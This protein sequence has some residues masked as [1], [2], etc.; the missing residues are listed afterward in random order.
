[1]MLR[2]SLFPKTLLSLNLHT[3]NSESSLKEFGKTQPYSGLKEIF[4]PFTG[5]KEEFWCVA[6]NEA[7]TNL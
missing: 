5:K 1:M 7:N 4:I 3:N 6:K 2:K